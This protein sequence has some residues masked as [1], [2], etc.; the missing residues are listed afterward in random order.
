MATTTSRRAL[1]SHRRW[2]IPT[3]SWDCAA[4]R[5]QLIVSQF[6]VSSNVAVPSSLS[7][8]NL[9]AL[10]VISFV[11]RFLLRSRPSIELIG[12]AER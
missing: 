9:Y 7:S 5:E 10:A 11:A 8:L 12:S 3:R 2:R 4:P 6:P 1:P